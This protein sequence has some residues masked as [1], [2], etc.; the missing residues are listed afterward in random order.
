MLSKGAFCIIV[1]PHLWI[2]KFVNLLLSAS[3]DM[4]HCDLLWNCHIIVF[5]SHAWSIVYT[6][7]H[8][9]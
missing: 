3:F 9:N 4:K 2:D 5:I 6:I 1:L 8:G 7:Y